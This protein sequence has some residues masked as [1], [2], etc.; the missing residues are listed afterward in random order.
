MCAVGQSFSQLCAFQCEFVLVD[1]VR[2]HLFISLSEIKTTFTC[3]WADVS[4][5][6][7]ADAVLTSPP[8]I[9]PSTFCLLTCELLHFGGSAETFLCFEAASAVC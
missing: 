2:E 8:G 9:K 4:A 7:S 1:L 3:D 6:V 5:D